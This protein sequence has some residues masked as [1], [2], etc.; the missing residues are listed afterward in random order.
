M[1]PHTILLYIGALLSAFILTGC[2]QKE[3]PFVVAEEKQEQVAF[4]F[5]LPSLAGDTLTMSKVA[6]GNR[7]TIIDFWASWCGPCRREM[8]FMKGLYEKYHDQGLGI[9]GVSLDESAEDW[10][11]AVN[12]L[13]LEW[14]QVSDLQGWNCAPARSLGVN[15]IPY[16]VVVSSQGEILTQGLRGEELETFVSQQLSLQ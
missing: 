12:E 2:K 1:R 9:L 15:S 3:R 14:P 11:G 8:P 13:E 10:R 7:L 16:T 6:A 5:S 4:D